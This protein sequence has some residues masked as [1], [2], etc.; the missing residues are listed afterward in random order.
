MTDSQP[1]GAAPPS[2][3]PA[4]AGKR[5]RL[6]AAARQLFHEQGVEKTTLAEIAA[7]AE[8]P[9]GNVFYYFKTKDAIVASVIAAYGDTQGAVSGMLDR[10]RTPQA[11]L[12]A[13]VRTWVDRRELFASHGC[14][15]GTLA[16]ELGKRDD[17]LRTEAGN[18]LL[19]LIGWV[20]EQFE[21]MGRRDARELAVALIAAYEGIALLANTLHDPALVSAEGRRLERWIDTLAP[22]DEVTRA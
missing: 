13:L 15:V 8:V 9:V 22:D 16:S 4:A 18:V 2:T 14:P 19:G 5:E 6:V 7:A 11:R 12:K 1:S 17:E 10:R 3:A 20:Q 21:A